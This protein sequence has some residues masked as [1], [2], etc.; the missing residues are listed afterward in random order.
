MEDNMAR[1]LRSAGEQT[2][3]A[4]FVAEGN[5]AVETDVEAVGQK[6]AVA[7]QQAVEV[8]DNVLRYKDTGP[9]VEDAQ[10]ALG[11]EVT[12]VFDAAT[13]QAVV[14]AQYRMGLGGS[15]ADG[16]YTEAVAAFVAGE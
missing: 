16:V 3:V 5:P 8:S 11:V 13:K 9:A 2:E 14:N 6:I 12:G 1:G 10:R 7:A 4:D 15:A